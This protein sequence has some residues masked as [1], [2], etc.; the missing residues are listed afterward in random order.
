VDSVV[1]AWGP[2]AGC[3]ECGDEPSGAG[4]T[5]IDIYRQAPLRLKICDFSVW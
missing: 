3:C 1:S 2:V 5:E 4:A